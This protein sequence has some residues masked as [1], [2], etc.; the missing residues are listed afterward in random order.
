[1][2]FQMKL[3][4]LI[5]VLGVLLFG[6]SV[7]ADNIAEFCNAASSQKMVVVFTPSAKIEGVIR[8]AEGGSSWRSSALRTKLTDLKVFLVS[9]SKTV[10]VQFA[11]KE[12]NRALE[13]L[14]KEL[15]SSNQNSAYGSVAVVN[16]FSKLQIA[17][18][19]A[20][21]AELAAMQSVIINTEL[22]PFA[23]MKLLYDLVTQ[24]ESVGSEAA[25]GGR[26]WR[27]DVK[28]HLISAKEE[29]LVVSSKVSSLKTRYQLLKATEVINSELNYLETHM[30]AYSA[31]AVARIFGHLDEYVQL[32][33]REESQVH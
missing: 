5:G 23:R 6:L 33:V 27:S 31:Q 26:W 18:E 28:S 16:L 1:M 19:N 15:Q 13:M 8:L 29:L 9:A 32:A 2:S 22:S 11:E 21:Q 3:S 4:M 20:I 24:I 17:I 10:S 7:R 25:Q 30:N 12:L 14:N